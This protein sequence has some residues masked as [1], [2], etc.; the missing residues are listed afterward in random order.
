VIAD[1]VVLDQRFVVEEATVELRLEALI[2]AL[3]FADT[4][5]KVAVHELD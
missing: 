5:G 1:L 3:D 4:V 2:Q